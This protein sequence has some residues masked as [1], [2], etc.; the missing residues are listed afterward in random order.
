[1]LF[2]LELFF[3]YWFLIRKSIYRRDLIKQEITPKSV[4]NKKKL[5][6]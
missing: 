6:L 4:N 1:M 3:D 5:P 2:F